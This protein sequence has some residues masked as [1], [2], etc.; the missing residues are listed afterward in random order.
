MIEVK[1]MLELFVLF[2]VCG[3]AIASLVGLMSMLAPLAQKSEPYFQFEGTTIDGTLVED[4]VEIKSLILANMESGKKDN[5]TIYIPVLKRIEWQLAGGANII[6][7][8]TD[9]FKMSLTL[10][11]HAGGSHPDIDDADHLFSRYIYQQLSTAATNTCIGQFFLTGSQQIKNALC[12][13]DAIY[14]QITLNGAAQAFKAKVYFDWEELTM[15]NFNL[16]F[17]SRIALA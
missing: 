2:L 13:S 3:I 6:D 16:E 1:K 17:L 5:P 14:F 12:V 7:T 9:V 8:A 11:T 4:S 10:Q 15:A